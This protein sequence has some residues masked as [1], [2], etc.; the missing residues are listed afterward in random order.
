MS[1]NCCSLRPKSVVPKRN[2]H[3]SHE[4]R[5]GLKGASSPLDSLS[6]QLEAASPSPRTG[7]GRVTDR[8]AGWEAQTELGEGVGRDFQ[9]QTQPPCQA[10]KEPA[11]SPAARSLRAAPVPVPA[12]WGTCCSAH[13]PKPPPAAPPTGS[14]GLLD[15]PYP[16]TPR[17]AQIEPSLLSHPPLPSL[18]WPLCNQIPKFRSS[19]GPNRGSPPPPTGCGRL[20]GVLWSGHDLAGAS[21]SWGFLARGRPTEADMTPPDFSTIGPPRAT[22]SAATLPATPRGQSSRAFYLPFNHELGTKPQDGERSGTKK[23]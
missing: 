17:Y 6:P 10:H 19:P 9:S 18:P 2:G 11:H 15:T 14:P 23:E 13:R 5:S 16:G 4:A 7:L 20:A 3:G 1:L 22:Q 8:E 12:A 21:C